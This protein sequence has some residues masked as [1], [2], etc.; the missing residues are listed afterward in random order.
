M[1]YLLEIDYQKFLLPDENG[2]QA[3][4]KALSKA[5]N[6]VSDARYDGGGLKIGPP[7]N[8]KLE[9]LPHFRFVKVA[10][11]N[12]DPDTPRRRVVEGELLPPGAPL[13]LP[14]GQTARRLPLRRLQIGKG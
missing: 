8:V 7:T 3:V 5:R 10:R 4:L 9:A 6:V 2:I 12:V 11:A 13:E 14:V 1:L